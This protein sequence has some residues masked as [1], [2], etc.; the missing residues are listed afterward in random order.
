MLGWSKSPEKKWATGR[1]HEIWGSGHQWV[2][3]FQPL[4]KRRKRKI[5]LQD[6]QEG[7]GRKREGNRYHCRP[8]ETGGEEN[9]DCVEVPLPY[10]VSCSSS[11]R[12]PQLRDKPMITWQRHRFNY[13]FICPFS[14]PSLSSS[15]Q[16]TQ[17]PWASP[18]HPHPVLSLVTFLCPSSLLLLLQLHPMGAI[19]LET[20]ARRHT[21]FYC[22]VSSIWDFYIPFLLSREWSFCSQEGFL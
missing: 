22:F 1:A 9:H 3:R 21:C 20:L 12:C 17:S 7:Q 8:E 4:V 13:L 11:L 6:V 10:L 15:I 18:S 16:C 14:S 2:D 19:Q 5:P